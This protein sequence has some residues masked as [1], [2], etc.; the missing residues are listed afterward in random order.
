MAL[1]REA[2]DL[3]AIGAYTPG[4]S[5]ALDDAVARWPLLETFLRQRLDEV[6]D[7]DATATRLAA[8]WRS[9]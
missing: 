5:P 7:V 9:P 3:R 1:H 8:I 4:T 6:D 2:R